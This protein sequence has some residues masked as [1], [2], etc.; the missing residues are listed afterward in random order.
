MRFKGLGRTLMATGVVCIIV[1]G[2]FALYPVASSA[3]LR[4]SNALLY[5]G[6]IMIVAGLAVRL[7][8][9]RT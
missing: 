6:I 2:L 3:A 1:Y 8:R 7:S 4:I 9:P 5:L